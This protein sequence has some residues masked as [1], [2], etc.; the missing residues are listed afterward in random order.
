MDENGKKYMDAAI[1]NHKILAAQPELTNILARINKLM[2]HYEKKENPA[3]VEKLNALLKDLQ[4]NPNLLKEN[5]SAI[6]NKLKE[7]SSE[8]SKTQGYGNQFT[9]LFHRSALAKEV[10]KIE[11]AEKEVFQPKKPK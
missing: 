10:G 8:Y 2:D 3:V 1:R 9:Q 5:K 6:T 11:K 7:I 4:N